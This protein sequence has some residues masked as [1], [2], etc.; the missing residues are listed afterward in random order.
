MAYYTG[1]LNKGPILQNQI[2]IKCFIANMRSAVD[3]REFSHPL[4][5]EN[6][7]PE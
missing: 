5:A 1:V 7:R 3:A 4:F 6:A 2:L